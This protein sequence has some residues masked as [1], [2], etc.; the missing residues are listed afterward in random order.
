MLILYNRFVEIHFIDADLVIG[1]RQELVG[2]RVNIPPSISFEAKHSSESSPNEAK[3]TI[4]NM[5]DD[6]REK[7]LVEGKKIEIHAGYWAYNGER[8]VGP[9]F[10]G[11]IRKT[12]TKVDNGTEVVS[13]IECGDGD[14]AYARARVR[15]RTGKAPTHKEVVGHAVDAF[16][17][18]GVTPGRIEIPDYTEAR[19]RT[20]DRAARRELDDICRQHDLQW[21]I[22]DGTLH[23]I[24]RN[25]VRDDRRLTISPDTG[26]LD[27]P[28]RSEH[29]VDIKTLLLHD[30]RP[31]QTIR[32]ENP[33]VSN[34]LAGTEYKIHEITFSG[35][36]F[37]GDFGCQIDG[38]G[39]NDPAQKDK[40]GKKNNR[41]GRKRKVKRSR[42]RINR[43]GT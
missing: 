39:L 12:L 26:L 9:I 42:E 36:N 13:E 21:S 20:I 33:Y 43:T 30:L 1:G 17:S 31:G 3:V 16:A 5:H 14:D 27:S 37:G 7:V 25:D 23:V 8:Y 6:T 24:S 40:A 10:R 4:Y 34:P 2:G 15:K 11:Q 19:P 35:D 38:R 18:L 29:G 28:Q 32:I 41:K 22:Q